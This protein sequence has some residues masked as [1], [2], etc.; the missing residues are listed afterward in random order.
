[1]SAA[2]RNWLILIAILIGLALTPAACR[3]LHRC[4]N[5]RTAP[6]DCSA[7]GGYGSTN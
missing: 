3:Y 5:P 1:M 6:M 2:A 7:P 4:D